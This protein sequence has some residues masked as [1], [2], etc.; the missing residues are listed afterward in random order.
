MSLR[1]KNQFCGPTGVIPPAGNCWLNTIFSRPIGQ[2]LR[3][4]VDRETDR[5]SPVTHLVLL[6]GPDTI[7]RAVVTVI[8]FAFDAV[9]VG[10]SRSHIGVE[11][12][13]R[14]KPSLTD[15]DT[16][17]AVIF[18]C[19]IGFTEAS[20]A[21]A[22]P[23]LTFDRCGQHVL[24]G[25]SHEFLSDCFMQASTASRI[26]GFEGVRADSC[27]PAAFTTTLPC[28]IR[29]A[30]SVSAKHCQLAKHFSAQVLKVIRLPLTVGFSHEMFLSSEG[31]LGLEPGKR[32]NAT[33]LASLYHTAA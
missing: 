4:S 22:V 3:G 12:L 16:T 15:A 6:D 7:F 23:A 17:S 18:V 9:F 30:I 33:R 24:S 27:V 20:L 11:I 19:L 8:V 2:S 21:N 5:H 32:F 13:S 28:S 10:R 14:F 31:R 29:G 26:T 25:V 1:F